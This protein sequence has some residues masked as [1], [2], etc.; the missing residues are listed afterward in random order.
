MGIC[1]N[2][3]DIFNIVY[4]RFLGKGDIDQHNCLGNTSFGNRQ[5]PTF[6]WLNKIRFC[7]I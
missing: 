2:L 5:I 4:G 3:S 6:Q 1:N 7:V